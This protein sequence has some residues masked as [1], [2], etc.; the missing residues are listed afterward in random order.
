M[1]VRHSPSVFFFVADIQSQVALGDQLHKSVVCLRLGSAARTLMMTPC[2]RHVSADLKETQGA[3]VMFL[4]FT[5]LATRV[6]RL[7]SIAYQGEN[8][9]EHLRISQ[10]MSA[11]TS[12]D[13]GLLKTLYRFRLLISV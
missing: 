3:R 11:A 1:L 8:R 7:G 13:S 12:H 4:V 5:L 9:L 6:L 2:W 10:R